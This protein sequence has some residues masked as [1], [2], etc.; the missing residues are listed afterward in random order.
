[1]KRRE[2]SWG[3][4]VADQQHRSTL[5]PLSSLQQPIYV[6]PPRPDPPTSKR[7]KPKT[8][9]SSKRKPPRSQREAAHNP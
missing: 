5:P 8:G 4:I 1:M 3:E 7:A 6:I 9:T 2:R